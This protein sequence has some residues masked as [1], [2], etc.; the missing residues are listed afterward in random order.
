MSARNSP[1][2]RTKHSGMTL[3]P[4]GNTVAGLIT[5][6]RRECWGSQASG[7]EGHRNDAMPFCFSG[8]EFCTAIGS[9]GRRLCRRAD[10]GRP[11]QSF[12]ATSGRREDD[13]RRKRSNEDVCRLRAGRLA[14]RERTDSQ[15]RAALRP[16]EG[17]D[18]RGCA[19][20][21]ERDPVPRYGESVRA[22]VR[23]RDQPL[24]FSGHR[25]DGGR[26]RDDRALLLKIDKRL[27]NRYQFLVSYT[28]SKAMDTSATN[29]LAARYGFYSIGRYGAADRRHRLVASGIVQLPAGF[30]L[31]TIADFR[32]SLRFTTSG[33]LDLNGKGYTNDLPAGA[34][35]GQ[36]LPRYESRRRQRVPPRTRAHRGDHGDCP[37]FANANLRTPFLLHAPRVKRGTSPCSTRHVATCSK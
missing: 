3:A 24:D 14:N 6:G 5:A 12:R 27:A 34:M 19:W 32:S 23:R 36:R 1:A 16:A 30:Q 31:S 21:S 17:I 4:A 2:F 20:P 26:Q 25:R 35:R 28:L 15:P 9:P 29:Q 7:A 22:S 11:L 33:S 13:R 18:Q 10:S 8:V 37:G